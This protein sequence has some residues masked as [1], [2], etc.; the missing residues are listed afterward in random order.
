MFVLRVRKTALA[1]MALGLLAAS[2]SLFATTLP[3]I[4]YTA[5]GTFSTPAVSGN[6]LFELAGGAFK[7]YIVANE[8]TR[9]HST[10]KGYATYVDLK[11]K[12]NVQ[13]GLDPSPVPIYGAHTFMVLAIGLDQDTVEIKG[14]VTVLHKSIT[15]SAKFALPKGTLTKY[16]IWPFSAAATLTP[17]S[18]TVT[19]SSSDAA[20][21]LTVAS[22]T[23]DAYRAQRNSTTASLIPWTP[24]SFVWSSADAIATKSLVWA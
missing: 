17:S 16:T 6:D 7:I 20:T 15:I 9:P 1:L 11:L 14:P 24:A 8:G 23:L 10:G 19:Y 18:G 4:V 22:G 13:S 5:S 2:G 21:V 12:G 3:N